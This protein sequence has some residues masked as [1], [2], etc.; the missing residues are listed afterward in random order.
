ML[1]RQQ[2]DCVP[3]IPNEFAE[4]YQRDIFSDMKSAIDFLKEF[5]DKLNT[6]HPDCVYKI[7]QLF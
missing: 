3:S 1:G 7:K 2:T 4:R 6:L 5:N